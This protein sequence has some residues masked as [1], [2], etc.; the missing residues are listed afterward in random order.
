MPGSVA[1]DCNY[2]GECALEANRHDL[3]QV[4]VDGA[5]SYM[6]V[7][8]K[9]KERERGKSEGIDWHSMNC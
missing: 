9:H 4:S 1:D 6:S 7:S 3:Q 2:P 8:L 5:I